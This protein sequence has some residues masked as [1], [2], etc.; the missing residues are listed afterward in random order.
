MIKRLATLGILCVLLVPSHAWGKEAVR[1]DDVAYTVSSPHVDWAKKLP[2]GAVRILLIAPRFT[3]RDAVELEQRLEAEI[4]TVPMWDA[5]HLGCDESLP[6][7]CLQGAE[8]AA[9]EQ[10]LG[11]LLDKTFDVIVLAACSPAALPVAAQTRLAALAEDGTGLVLVHLRGGLGEPLGNL[12][13]ALEPAGP[14]VPAV[15]QAP[16]EDAAA[17]FRFVR[18]RY[19]E[20]RVAELDFPGDAPATHCLIQP[21]AGYLVAPLS[22]HEDAFSLAVRAVLWAG[23]RWDGALIA[24]AADESPQGPSNEEIPPDLPAEYVEAIR[25]P[26]LTQPLRPYAL[27]LDAPAERDYR[28]RVAV[29]KAER[30]MRV[31]YAPM[32]PLFKKGQYYP[33]DLFIGPGQ[34]RV[35]FWLESRK[36]LEDWLVSSTTVRSWPRFSELEL[37]KTWV[38]PNDT[39][40][41]SLRMRPIFT[42]ERR[43]TVYVR[44]LD[45]WPTAGR[46]RPSPGSVYSTYR[47]TTGRSAIPR[48][49]AEARVPAGPEGGNINVELSF[50]DLIAPILKLEVFA[51]DGPPR[52]ISEMA[53]NGVACEVRFVQVRTR[54][55]RAKTHLAVSAPAAAEYNGRF[56]LNRLRGLGVDTA[57]GPA[58]EAARYSTEFLG[59][60]YVPELGPY[61]A[62]AAVDG[63]IRIPCLSDPAYRDEQSVLLKKTAAQYWAGGSKRVSLGGANCLC[64]SDD[65]V[66]ASSFCTEAFQR[67]LRGAYGELHKLNA[68]WGAGFDAWE[69]VYAPPLHVLREA[70]SFAPWV[71]FQRHMAHVFAGFHGFAR[72]QLHSVDGTLK[73]GFGARAGRNPAYGYD[74]REILERVDYVAIDPDPVR[75]EQV[76]CYQRA[77]SASALAFGAGAPLTGST[78]ARWL[79]WYALLHGLDTL[80]CQ[81]PYGT[82]NAAAPGAALYPDGRVTPAFQALA[83]SYAHVSRGLG[84]LLLEAQR[85]AAPI[86]LLDSDASRYLSAAGP[87][88]ACTAE[89]AEEAFIGLIESL[90]LQF[91]FVAERDVAAGS[92]APYK[93][94]VLPMARALSDTT[95]A[96]L[97]RYV[98]QGGALLADTAPAIFDGHG[99]QREHPA[100]DALFGVVHVPQESEAG[101]AWEAPGSLT[102]LKAE[103]GS[104]RAADPVFRPCTALRTDSGQ[105]E[106]SA[107]GAPAWVVN[108]GNLLLNHPLSHPWQAKGTPR[109]WLRERLGRYFEE[110]GCEP[111][112]G[113]TGDHAETEALRFRFGAARIHAL[114]AHHTA[115]A[116]QR[117]VLEFPRDAFVFD[118]LAGGPAKGRG[119]LRVSLEAG[120][121]RCFSELPYKVEALEL[122]VPEGVLSGERLYVRVALVTEEETPGTH[123]IQVELGPAHGAPLEHYTRLLRCD[124]GHGSTYIPLAVNETGGR[125]TLRA[126]DVLTGVAAEATLIVGGPVD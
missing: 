38:L 24:K 7:A 30:D 36:G 55:E 56:Y 31:D 53:L 120:E 72:D 81:T 115:A 99:A 92:L 65:A 50:A 3:L 22:Y 119:K 29:R 34:S 64:A 100:L 66:C 88:F 45:P 91:D 116:A 93:V 87:A 74:W 112:L 118:L 108:E 21:P 79:P 67:F 73:A 60:R 15:A 113:G 98:A 97:E 104:G 58:D 13:K 114:L 28:V 78:Q 62:E 82:A 101:T 2:G 49:V 94:V 80:W 122:T 19:G 8:P 42:Q 4:E 44:A 126:A 102:S 89:Q 54:P 48:V 20:G 71:D 17:R 63:D 32:K 52:H 95:A 86:A 10:R 84:A 9:M 18:G 35:D 26:V 125:Y 57:F 11:R 107:S 75:V 61:A 1:P 117:A 90:A 33:I 40:G 110:A 85:E 6:G 39:L 76:R 46:S 59:F 25:E 103:D 109:A 121:A 105:A 83:D 23:G 123:L 111:L 27:W 51:V 14:P 5:E 70:R 106:A 16:P 68:S 37:D 41:L 69:E 47:A 124:K 77:T 12:L 43:A 96:A